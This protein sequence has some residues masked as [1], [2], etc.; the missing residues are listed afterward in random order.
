[1]QTVRVQGEPDRTLAHRIGRPRVWLWLLFGVVAAL[2]IGSLLE[3]AAGDPEHAGLAGRDAGGHYA[4]V[5][6]IVFDGDLDVANQ[7]GPV[8]M[9]RPE[10]PGR[11]RYPVGQALM[12]MP[13]FLIAHGLALTLAAVGVPVATNGYGMVYGVVLSLW[14]IGLVAVASSAVASVVRQRL[15]VSQATATA[16]VLLWL[17][18]THTLYYLV[19]TPLNAHHSGIILACLIVWA[20]HCGLGS[21]RP[22]RWLALAGLAWTMATVTRYTNGLSGVML[23]PLIWRVVTGWRGMI[24]RDVALIG[25]ALLV[26]VA[27]VGVQLAAVRVSSE[28][29]AF[30]DESDELPGRADL[31]EPVRRHVLAEGYYPHEGFVW[32]DPA[33]LRIMLSSRGGLLFETPAVAVALVCIWPYRR[34]PLVVCFSVWFVML[35]YVNASWWAWWFGPRPSNRAFLELAPLYILGLTAFWH[36]VR[37][38]RWR[39]VWVGMLVA[40]S[41][42]ACLANRIGLRD[43]RGFIIPIEQRLDLTR[44]HRL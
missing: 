27:A 42:L 13:P 9:T 14:V 3:R 6:S 23:L 12:L 17:G 2:A 10:N 39:W 43:E 21:P 29:A 30:A 41:L 8:Y 25:G 15:G 16:G 7:P 36:R 38:S 19:R 22:L 32:H 24:G 31:V 44:W 18:A 1:M 20:V 33:W 40:C 34:D 28:P 37:G 35:W 11:N 4:F 26:S 5:P